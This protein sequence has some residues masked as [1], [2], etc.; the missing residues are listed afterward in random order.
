LERW[1]GG[2][3]GEK[4][5]GLFQ[6]KK[7]EKVQGAETKSVETQLGGTGKR[8]Q[9]KKPGSGVLKILG[10]SGSRREEHPPLGGEGAEGPHS[11]GRVGKRTKHAGQLF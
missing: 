10:I 3:G 4:K 2:G 8:K 7:R 11:G 9:R 5:S 1:V 6:T